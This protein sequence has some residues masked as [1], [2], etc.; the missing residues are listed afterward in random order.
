M[1]MMA[2]VLQDKKISAEFIAIY[3]EMLVDIPDEVLIKAMREC[4]LNCRFF[5]T[6]AEIRNYAMPIL[7]EYNLKNEKLLA[8]NLLVKCRENVSIS[9][10]RKTVS[11]Q[12]E[13][14]PDMCEH[15]NT[16]RCKKF[17][18]QK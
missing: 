14:S 13:I 18:V 9:D 17:E 11:C 12:L 2:I 5:P 10:D 4:L 3:Q 6:I 16:G 7:Q 8:E 1:G 15:A